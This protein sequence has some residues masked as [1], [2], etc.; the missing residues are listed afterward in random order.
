MLETNQNLPQLY[1]FCFLLMGDAAKAQ[2]A[3][4]ATLRE[5]ALHSAQGES[6]PDRLWF[7]RDA[8][9]RCLAASEQGIQAE[10]LPMEECEVA[11]H[12]AAQVKQLHPEQLA[13]WISAAPEP[14]RSALA[15]YYLDEFTSRELLQLLDLKPK[16]LSHLICEG[17]RQFQAWLDAVMPHFDDHE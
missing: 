4:Q 7:F 5:A 17:R 2:E 3:F 6:P 11:P 13:V 16:E 8:R 9:W 14:Q 12:A 1:R 10:E 15:A